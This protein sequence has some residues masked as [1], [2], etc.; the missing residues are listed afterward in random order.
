LVSLPTGD[1]VVEV[2]RASG[3]RAPVSPVG[4]KKDEDEEVELALADQMDLLG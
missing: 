1:R 3:N 4:T 2:T